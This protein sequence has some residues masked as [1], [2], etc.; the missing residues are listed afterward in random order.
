MKNNTSNTKLILLHPYIQKQGSSSKLWLLAFISFFTIAFLLTLP[1]LDRGGSRRSQQRNGVAHS[2]IRIVRDMKLDGIV[3]FADDSNV[4]NME[5]FDEIQNLKWFGAVS[6][7]MLVK[8][9]NADETADRKNNEEDNYLFPVQGPICNA[10]GMLIG[11]HAGKTG[12]HI[13]DRATVSPRKFEWSGFVLN[14]RLLWK[15]GGENPD[16]IKDIDTLDGD[17]DN[18]LGLIKDHSMMEPLGSCGRRVLVWWLRVE[19]HADSKFP[20]R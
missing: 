14:S 3:M 9:A 1:G 12:V 20:P 13:G 19:A 15:D 10:P 6:I 5:L 16:W 2:E 17:I 7:G 8:T 11:W 18:P 4:H